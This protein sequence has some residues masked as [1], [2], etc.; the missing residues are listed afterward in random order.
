PD[1]GARDAEIGWS[2][3]DIGARDAEIGW[4]APDIGARDAD[5]RAVCRRSWGVDPAGV[6]LR[7]EPGPALA[8]TGLSCVWLIGAPDVGATR[9]D[10]GGIRPDLGATPPDL[11]DA[12][13]DLGGTRPD[14]G[15]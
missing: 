4:S 9:P 3:P 10:L 2:A 8:W 14:I 12:G 7:R 5:V 15:G 1:I 11:S 13:P 6:M